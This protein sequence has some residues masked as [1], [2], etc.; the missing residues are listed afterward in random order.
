LLPSSRGA[1]LLQLNLLGAPSYFIG[2]QRDFTSLSAE[3]FFLPF[4]VRQ[5]LRLY[6]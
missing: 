3:N 1:V 5:R 6:L 2:L 4:C